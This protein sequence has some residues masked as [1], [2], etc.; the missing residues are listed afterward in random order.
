MIKGKGGS[1]FVK[2]KE[3]AY[4]NMCVGSDIGNHCL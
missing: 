2:E 4:G 1:V 3:I